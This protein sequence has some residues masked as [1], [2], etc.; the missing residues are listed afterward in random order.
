VSRLQRKELAVGAW[1]QVG[2]YLTARRVGDSAADFAIVD[3]EHL[4]FSL[5]DLGQ[6]LQW[7]I[8]RRRPGTPVAATP[9]VRVPA[10]GAERNQWI[11]KQVLDYGAFGVIAPQVRT[12]DD[13][14]CAASAM[15][16]PASVEG[17]PEGV[18]GAFPDQAARY[19]GMA[20][21]ADYLS[22]ADL[23]PLSPSGQLMLIILVEHVEAWNAI[24]EL[25]QAPGVGAVFWGPGDGS[26]SLGYRD[27]DPTNPQ[28]DRYKERVIAACKNHGVAVGQPGVGD[29]FR[30]VDEGFDFFGL[31]GYADA[32]LVRRLRDHYA[33]RP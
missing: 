8:S 24:D 33:Q 14:A 13:I 32:D 12:V 5:P 4:G 21:T 30:S 22:L 7:M 2:D 18:R 11:Y 15:R 3:M 20:K 17:G 10:N 25:V 26:M 27:N 9:I 23:W 16:Y 29:P 1:V 19:W 6:T 31:P 28:L